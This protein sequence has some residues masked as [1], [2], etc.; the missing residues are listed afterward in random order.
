MESAKLDVEVSW[1]VERTPKS[2]ALQEEASR[3]PARRQLPG[4][5][6][7]RAVPV[8]RRTRRRPLRPRRRRQP[9]P[10]LHAQRHHAHPGTRAPGHHGR[11]TGAGREGSVLQRPDRLPSA[12]READLRPRAVH[13]LGTVHELR[14]RGHAVRH[15]GRPGVHRKAQ[16][17]EV[18]GRLPRHTRVRVGQLQPVSGRARPRRAELDTGVCRDAARSHGR[19]GR[20]AVQR[21]GPNRAHHPRP[22]RRPRVRHHGAGRIILRLPA[23]RPGLPERR[24]RVDGGAWHP[25]RIRRGAEPAGGARR[26]AGAVRRDAPT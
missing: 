24:P 22:R 9:L 25:A 20:A 19:R 11:R 16:D 17:R 1:Y 12:A 8:L 26:R 2:K 7:L 6:V 10:G 5:A 14:H 3:V 21:P 18:R 4:D 13:R 15:Q 23:G